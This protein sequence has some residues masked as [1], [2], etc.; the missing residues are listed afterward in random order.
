VSLMGGACE[1]ATGQFVVKNECDES[2]KVKVTQ[3]IKKSESGERNVDVKVDG[4][5]IAEGAQNKEDDPGKAALGMTSGL[6]G[7]IGGKDKFTYAMHTSVATVGPK[8][9]VVFNL[10]SGDK[11]KR[12]L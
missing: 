3:E 8:K 2:V 6:S 11:K 4:G 7:G 5:A 9:F 1:P 10:P 12:F